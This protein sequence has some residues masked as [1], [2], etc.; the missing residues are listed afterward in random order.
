[1]KTAIFTSLLATLPAALA[2]PEVVAKPLP[3][4]CASYPG[5]NAETGVAGPWVLKLVNSE[6]TAIDGFSD[7]S[8]YS[9]SFNPRT[10]RKPTLRWG[11]INFPTRNDIAKN[12][13][14]CRDGKLLAWVPTDLTDAGAP[15]NYQWVPLV[16]S[17]YPYDASL[18]YKIDGTAPRIFEHYID[19]E[20]QPGTF[21]GG[22]D[23]TT[24]WGLKYYPA[25]VGSPRD[26]YYTRLLGPNSADPT[27]GEKLNANETRS[28][29]S[30]AA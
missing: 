14:Q 12:P 13:L 22:Y 2:L 6:N 28:F 25:N 8:H 27:T 10:D 17:P 7:T 24:A 29:I 20:K 1:M 16:L 11:F 30:I 9:I 18:M 3:E 19:G 26:Y 4:G 21:L 15:T 5:Y 23:N